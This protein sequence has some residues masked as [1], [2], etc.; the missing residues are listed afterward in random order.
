MGI[1]GRILTI[2]GVTTTICSTPV[3][4]FLNLIAVAIWP[5]WVAVAIC[6][7]LRKVCIDVIVQRLGDATAAGMY[8]LLF[9]TLF[10]E[11][12]QLSPFVL[13]QYV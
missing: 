10:M 5:T 1:K 12:P 3:V 4:A 8:K 6:E 9:S 2:A 7:T 13:C 11:G